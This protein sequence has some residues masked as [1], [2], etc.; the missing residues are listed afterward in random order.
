MVDISVSSI[1]LYSSSRTLMRR[2]GYTVFVSFDQPGQAGEVHPLGSGS[3]VPNIVTW[4]RL[5]KVG[6]DTEPTGRSQR[7][8]VLAAP[9]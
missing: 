2:P 9:S 5:K 8:A 4:P 3:R 1:G 6:G 7:L